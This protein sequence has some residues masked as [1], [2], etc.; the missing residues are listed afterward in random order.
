MFESLITRKS[1]KY[2]TLKICQ[3]FNRINYKNIH[4]CCLFGTIINSSQNLLNKNWKWITRNYVNELQQIIFS[5]QLFLKAASFKDTF[6]TSFWKHKYLLVIYIH[7]QLEVIVFIPLLSRRTS[8][9]RIEIIKSV[10]I[11]LQQS[12]IHK[13]EWKMLLVYIFNNMF[14]EICS[15]LK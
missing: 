2:K 4:K 6:I 5:C 1:N 8:C 9:R 12:L 13:S 7:S 11:N 15:Q 3:L 10:I 14:T